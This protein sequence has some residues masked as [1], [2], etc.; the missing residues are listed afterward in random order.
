[1]PASR[2]PEE[3]FDAFP[4]EDLLILLDP[5]CE[6]LLTKLLYLLSPPLGPALS[7]HFVGVTDKMTSSSA[8]TMT[9]SKAGPSL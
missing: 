4:Y 3:D 2:P 7:C 9:L 8:F 6:Q 5:G 1:M